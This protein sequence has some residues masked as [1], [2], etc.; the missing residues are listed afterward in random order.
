MFHCA[1]LPAIEFNPAEGLWKVN[2]KPMVA[3]LFERRLSISEEEEPVPD[4]TLPTPG[5]EIVSYE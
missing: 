5:P 4:V 3:T 2:F 1:D